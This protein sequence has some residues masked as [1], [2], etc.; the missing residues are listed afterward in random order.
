MAPVHRDAPAP[1]RPPEP[2]RDAIHLGPAGSARW[3]LA[4]I[5]FTGQ[6]AGEAPVAARL[7][8]PWLGGGPS[9]ELWTAPAEAR[10]ARRGAVTLASAGPVAFAVAE[11]ADAAADGLDAATRRAF[12]GLLAATG[13]GG[14]RHLLRVWSAVPRINE[15]DAGL[16]RYRR[17]CRAR[18]EVFER[19]YGPGFATRLPASTAVGSRAGGLVVA[20]LAARQPGEHRENPR[21]VAAW[22][23]PACYGPRSPSF[24]R[25]TLCPPDAGGHL[26]ISGTAAIVGHASVHA[27]SPRLQTRETLGNLR[28]LLGGRGA[29]PERRPGRFRVYLRRSADLPEVQAELRRAL[30]EGIPAVFAEADICRR[31]LLVEIEAVA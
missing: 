19:W 9:A 31:E 1:G 15:P 17:F 3:P 21:Q 8:L 28:R 20:M 16:E 29:P 14:Y 25:A 10:V 5:G 26:L 11:L 18:A 30:G 7:D 4:A 24:A 6:A 13:E 22:A 2:W 27:G 12:G 23:Y